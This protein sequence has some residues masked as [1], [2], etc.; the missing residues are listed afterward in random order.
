MNSVFLR[1]NW[2]LLSL[3]IAVLIKIEKVVNNNIQDT[4][5]IIANGRFSLHPKKINGRIVT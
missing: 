4:V 2:C 1:H 5:K 3:K